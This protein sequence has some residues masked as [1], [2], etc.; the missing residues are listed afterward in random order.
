MQVALVSSGPK[1]TALSVGVLLKL[2]PS[3]VI[4]VPPYFDPD[5]GEMLLINILYSNF[6]QSSV[7]STALPTF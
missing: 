1:Y 7:N 5:V 6:E 3:I 4:K 2:S